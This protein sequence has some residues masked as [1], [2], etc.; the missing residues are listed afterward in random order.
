MQSVHPRWR[1]E[2]ASAAQLRP[3][4]A[5][6]SPLARGTR[7]FASS[8]TGMFW[9]IPAGAG[10]TATNCART[11][12][13]PVH[14]R[15]RGEHAPGL[16]NINAAAGSS[17]LARGTRHKAHAPGL[18]LRFIPAG[19]GNTATAPT[20][21]TWLTVHPR[22]RGE[23]LLCN[24]RVDEYTGSSPLARGT[25]PAELQ[26]R[27]HRRFIPAGAGNTLSTPTPVAPPA[28][29]P[30]WR[31][32]HGAGRRRDRRRV[33]S[34]PLAR[35]T[36]PEL[37]ANL[38]AAPVHP[39]WRGEHD[40]DGKKSDIEGGSSPLARGTRHADDGQ[41]VFGRFIPAGAGNTDHRRET[42][43][44]EAVHPRWRGEHYFGLRECEVLAGSSPLAR[45]TQNLAH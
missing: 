24:N 25:R 17:P 43:Q 22:W 38:L 30:R 31:G 13:N 8:R 29:H 3:S 28:V 5:G 15:W 1:G 21:S 36:P 6:S 7:W 4:S 44:P 34:S 2:H 27:R 35:G 32:E 26:A 19:A 11:A 37:L 14:P 23:H 45:G 18:H 12:S 39:R 33:G 9:F 20:A 16:R 41:A 10:N 40:F 42:N